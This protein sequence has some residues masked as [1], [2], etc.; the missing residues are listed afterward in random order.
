MATF[1]AFTDPEER[2][3]QSR[4]VEHHNRSTAG[5]RHLAVYLS[6]NVRYPA[7]LEEYIYATQ[8]LQAE[9]MQSA[10]SGWRR[11]WGGPGRFG[12]GG[13]LVWQLNDCWPGT[14]WSLVDVFLRPKAAYFTTKRALAP[15]TVNLRAATDGT[16]ALWAT[17]AGMSPLAA[18]VRLSRWSFAGE[19]EGEATRSVTLAPNQTTEIGVL[20]WPHDPAHVL[21]ATLN[22]AGEIVARAAL[23]PE[24]FK[25]LTP[26]DPGLSIT[27]IAPRTLRIAV[28]RPAKG[29]L[30]FTP[31]GTHLSDNMLDLIPG[32]PQRIRI[33]GSTMDTSG[34]RLHLWSLAGEHWVPIQGEMLT[35][36]TLA[37]AAP[38]EE[39]IGSSRPRGASYD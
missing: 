2:Y 13:A 16:V 36:P 38:Y 3:P 6:D 14:S 22:V 26:P 24:P 15:V 4:T 9:A 19:M 25:Y 31:D 21:S 20:D 39:R 33:E 18:Q 11:T 29:V 1:A 8:L 5:Y 37:G 28:E 32:E 10:I 27:Q 17:T 35:T 34:A 30:I 23:W 12:C 7:T